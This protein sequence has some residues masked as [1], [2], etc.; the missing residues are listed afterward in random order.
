MGRKGSDYRE[1]G[2]GNKMNASKTVCFLIFF[3]LTGSSLAQ[4][5]VLQNEHF[6]LV[7][8]PGSQISDRYSNG[9]ET[10]MTVEHEGQRVRVNWS[11]DQALFHFPTSTVR[12]RVTPDGIS[13][14]IKL[15][16]DAEQYV[17]KKSPREIGWLLGDQQ[18]YFQTRG[19]RVSKVIGPSDYLKLGRQSQWGRMSLT[20][21]IGTTDT[22][23]NSDG[24]LETFDGPE[25]SEH[26]YLV[27]GLALQ[28][29]P[30]TLRVPLP[31]DPF[32][33]GLP[34]D[35]YLWVRK[36]VELPPE[37]AARSAPVRE[38]DPLEAQPASWGSPELKAKFNDPNEDPLAA[39]KERRVKHETDPLKARSAPDSE[40]LLRV[41]D[42]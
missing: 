27:R 10:R 35:R 42:Y 26:L 6:E 38:E 19:G 41:K 16:F 17:V 22:L 5:P 14:T 20:S 28:A 36:E 8:A 4:S 34:A 13:N 33:N 12:V 2:K 39:K 23:L 37:P 40:E 32:L 11:N 29:G 25:F 18:I 1:I 31:D 15:N 3:L 24:K 9:W 21:S 30:I 7:L